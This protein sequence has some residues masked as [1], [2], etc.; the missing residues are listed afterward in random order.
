MTAI[1][2]RKR[3]I[4]P[5]PE[6]GPRAATGALSHLVACQTVGEGGP[7]AGVG[8]P[9]AG[10]AGVVGLE[11]ESDPA[12]AQHVDLEVGA[13]DDKGI[14][15]GLDGAAEVVLDLEGLGQPA[16]LL[17]ERDVGALHEHAQAFDA[18]QAFFEK[19]RDIQLDELIEPV[20]HADHQGH[21]L[22]LDD[23]DL[24][25]GS[26]QGLEFEALVFDLA[27]DVVVVDLQPVDLLHDL[28]VFGL[29]ILRFD[30]DPVDPLLG[31]LSHLETVRTRLHDLAEVRGEAGRSGDKAY[32]EGEKHP[33]EDAVGRWTSNHP[34]LHS[35]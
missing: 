14:L 34:H 27:L 24:A 18:G 6:P 31:D 15:V 8:I 32:H 25:E 16:E 9:L 22:P 30:D 23:V 28:L 2:M 1:K 29:E 19:E 13:L 26:T 3:F 11:V 21:D 33:T 20:E 35:M 17:G 5:P 10:R 7:V 12:Q 4:S